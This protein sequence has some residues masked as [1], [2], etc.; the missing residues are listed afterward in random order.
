MLDAVQRQ[1]SVVQKIQIIIDTSQLQFSSKVDEMPV[2]VQRQI[3]MVQ[4]VKKTMEIPQLQCIDKVVDDLV[5]QIPQMQVVDKTVEGPQ[6][7]ILNRS[8]RPQRTRRSRAFRPL[9]TF[10]SGAPHRRNE[11]RRP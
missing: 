8:L 5:V 3:P 9:C 4:I 10:P 2:A 1:V 11:V 6:V 7:Q